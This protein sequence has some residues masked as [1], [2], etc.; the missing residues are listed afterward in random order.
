MIA[1]RAFL[2]GIFA[3]IAA[4]TAVTI[5]HHGW[6]LLPVFFGDMAEMAWPGQF[7]VDFFTFLLMAGL[8]LAWRHGFRPVGLAL[9]TA[10]VFG[11]MLFLSA[12]LLIL[13]FVAAGDVRV[14]LL[15]R[16]RAERA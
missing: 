10:A 3:A 6:N 12:Y 16:P 5:R 13:S 9:G 4:Y 14:M 15:G 1:F 7:N 8:W 2:A 11:G